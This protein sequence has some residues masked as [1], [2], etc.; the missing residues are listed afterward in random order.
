MGWHVDPNEMSAFRMVADYSAITADCEIL[1]I[2]KDS[3]VF[4]VL[5]RPPRGNIPVFRTFL[6]DLIL[7]ANTSRYA[8]TVGGDLNLHLL[9]DTS[10]AA[11][12]T[13]LLH[14]HGFRNFIKSPTRVT[15]SASSS[16]PT[17]LLLTR[18]VKLQRLLF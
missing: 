13:L 18:Q 9:K 4:A 8:L 14:C 12:F 5:Y 2:Q 11:D 16:P 3:S 1:C 15:T 17:C 10:S 6:E 7:Y